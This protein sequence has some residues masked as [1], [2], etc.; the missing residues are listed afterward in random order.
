MPVF[1]YEMKNNENRVRDSIE[2]VSDCAVMLQLSLSP[3]WHSMTA[4]KSCKRNVLLKFVYLLSHSSVS[5]HSSALRPM[6]KS[7]D[8][9]S[10]SPI[11]Q[12]RMGLTKGIVVTIA[13]TLA[14][15]GTVASFT[16]SDFICKVSKYFIVAAWSACFALYKYDCRLRPSPGFYPTISFKTLELPITL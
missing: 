15:V 10:V 12:R 6:D 3:R 4:R 8:D 11:S 9:N 16:N 5:L 2:K 13:Y 1:E 14:K 7:P